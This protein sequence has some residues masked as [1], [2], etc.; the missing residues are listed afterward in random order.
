MKLELTPDTKESDFTKHG[1]AA[2]PLTLHP[3]QVETAVAALL[4][5]KPPAKPE[6]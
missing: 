3:L 4:K 5:V 6:K 2:K 1:N